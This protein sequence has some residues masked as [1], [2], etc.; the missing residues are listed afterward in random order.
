MKKLFLIAGLLCCFCQIQAQDSLVQYKRWNVGVKGGAT[1]S[2]VTATDEAI[3][4]N[5]FETNIL[6]RITYGAIVRYMTEKNFGLQI[7]ANYVEKG[8]DE[9]F[10]DFEGRRDPSLIYRVN[11]NYLEVPL[12]AYG[13][14]GRRNVQIFLNLGMFGAMLLSQNIERSANLDQEEITYFYTTTDQNNFD[15]GIRG[16]SGIAI[17]TKAGTFQL[18]GTYSLGLNSVLDRYRTAVPSIIQNQT[19]TVTLGYLVPFGSTSR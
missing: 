6:Q 12:L 4:R 3:V 7:E 11:L 17:A 5:R 10:R 2:Y 1:L 19:I 18:E 9:L 8:W 14:F 13:Y 16:G 15:L